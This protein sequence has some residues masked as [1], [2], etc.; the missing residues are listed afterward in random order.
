MSDEPASEPTHGPTFEPFRW[1]DFRRLFVT[2]ACATLASRA[3]A[4]VLGYQVYE[5][6]GEPLALGFLGLIEAIPALSLAL[7]GGHVADRHDRRLVL[8]V[9]LLA[10]AVCGAVLCGV[11]LYESGKAQLIVLYAVVLVVGVARGFAEPAA[12]ALEAQVVPWELLVR[13]STLMASCWLTGAVIGPLWGGVSFKFLGPAWTYLIIGLLY[14]CGW[15]AVRWI[16]PR[17]NPNPKAEE[18]IWESISVGVR[19]V[20]NDQVLLASMA[21]DLFAVLFGGAIALL[22]VFAKDILHVGPIGLGVLN[23]APTTGALLTMLWATH[24]PPVRHAGRNLFLAVGGFGIAMIVFALSET[25]WIS[26]VALFFSGVFD[27]VSVVIRRAILRLL[28]PDHLRGRIA[29][30]GMLFIGSSNELGA[31]ESGI[32]AWLLGTAPAVW[33]GGIVTM[34]IVAGAAL[35]APKLRRLSLDPKLI[36]KRDEQVDAELDE[37]AE[38]GELGFPPPH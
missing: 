12:A 35:C 14:F 27:G 38:Q 22:P 33:A 24:S 28:S 26:V 25:M 30:V 7:Y 19:Y 21:L 32:A 20:W 3:L 2:T 10:L 18:S 8:H 37:A 36:A 31:F 16:E 4:V 5:I 29:S 13:S 1:P 23:A 15:L 17:P 6:T 34:V 9:T 11:S